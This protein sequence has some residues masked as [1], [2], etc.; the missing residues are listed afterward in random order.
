MVPIRCR[1]KNIAVE[2]SKILRD[3]PIKPL[4]NAM[5]WIEY[6]LRHKNTD[7][8]RIPG[9]DLAWYEYWLIDVFALL[10]PFVALFSYVTFKLAI[11]ALTI[12]KDSET[13]KA[14]KA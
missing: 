6:V 3:Q 8:L 2:R 12:L 7:H 10:A 11:F 13:P 9:I 4:D 14:K 5:F 1:Y